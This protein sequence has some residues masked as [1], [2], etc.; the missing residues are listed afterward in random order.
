MNYN[1]FK[2]DRKHDCISFPNGYWFPIQDFSIKYENGNYHGVSHLMR[3]NWFNESILNELLVFLKSEFPDL[4][5]KETVANVKNEQ[6]AIAEFF[7]KLKL[8]VN[9]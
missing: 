3:K 1:S 2:V 7:K 8:S 6:V 4:D 9:G 5:F